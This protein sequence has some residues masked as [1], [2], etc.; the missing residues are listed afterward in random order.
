MTDIGLLVDSERSVLEKHFDKKWV[1]INDMFDYYDN[2]LITDEFDLVF[3]QYSIEGS[4]RGS[5]DG[6]EDFANSVLLLA[7]KA[8]R[9]EADTGIPHLKYIF[10]HNGSV[11]C[12]LAT[13]VNDAIAKIDEIFRK[14]IETE[15]VIDTIEE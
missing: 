13:S 7:E 14:A 4:Y 3:N 6:L 2:Y 8:L 15:T 12:I 11:Y 1:D 10:D 5:L 9:L